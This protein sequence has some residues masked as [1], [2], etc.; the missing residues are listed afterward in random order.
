MVLDSYF[1]LF[2]PSSFMFHQPRVKRQY[3]EGYISTGVRDSIFSIA[4]LLLE[5]RTDRPHYLADETSD[6]LRTKLPPQLLAERANAVAKQAIRPTLDAVQTYYNLA[7]YWCAVGGTQ[8]FQECAGK[9]DTP[10]LHSICHRH[11]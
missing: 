7:A 4:L 9:A 1:L 5:A 6:L 10:V 8:K 11:G 2:I 3:I